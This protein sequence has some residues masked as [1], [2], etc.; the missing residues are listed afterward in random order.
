MPV[1][2]DTGRDL[3][4]LARRAVEAFEE[5]ATRGRDRD[6][7][8]DTAFARLFELYQ[9][10]SQA[11]RQSPA[12]QNFNA[13]LAEVLVSGNNPVRISLY[14]V[15]TQT[16]A[17][18]GQHEGYRPACWRRSMLQLLGDEFVPLQSFLRPVDLDALPRIDDALEAVAANASPAT[19]EAVPSWVPE[20]H[21]WWW[22]PAR[23]RGEETPSH[24][25]AD[26]GTLDAVT[27]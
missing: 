26:S 6:A 18:N 27:D 23:Q 8:M 19:V 12:G 24:T 20:T 2:A 25:R 9:A 14:V 5:S 3:P 21:W 7:L 11:E 15:R 13:R 17:E 22:E 16:A 10:T 4:G 1:G